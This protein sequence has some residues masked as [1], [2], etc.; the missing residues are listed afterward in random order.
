MKVDHEG[1]ERDMR[2]GSARGEAVASQHDW[3]SGLPRWTARVLAA[4]SVVTLLSSLLPF[5][6]HL[7]DTPRTYVDQYYF[8]V[9]DTSFAWAF[10]VMVLAGA[11]AGRKRLAWWLL[12]LYLL[13]YAVSNV[14]AAAQ[15]PSAH[16]IVAALVGAA[17]L[18]VLV[19]GYREFPARVRP[20]NV[21]KAV[22]VLV[23]GLVAATLLGWAL[24]ELFPGTLPRDERLAWAAND[25]LAFGNVDA[26]QFSGSTHAFINTVLGA[27]SAL[28][29]MA[30]AVVLLRSQRATNALTG[31]EEAAL[32]GLIGTHGESDSLA[33]FATRRDKAAVFAP[34]GRAAVTYRVEV[35]VCL[36][37]G[38]PIGDPAAWPQAIDAWLGLCATYGWTPAAMGASEV[39][40]TAY[41]KA[42]L[43][44]LELG[45]EAILLP[46]SFTIQGAEMK[47]VRQ[48]VT[49][50]ARAGV[51]AR[52][53]RHSAI[54]TAE[55][56]AAVAHADQWRDT[57]TERGFSMALG[58]LGDPA[59][60]DCLL[61][62]AVAADG[63]VVAMLSLAP[64]GRAGVSLDLMRRD[65]QAP[66]G[67][68]EFMVSE[69]MGQA[70]DLGINRVSLNFAVFR[71]VFEEGGKLGAGPVLRLWRSVL[72][73]FSRWWQLESLYRSNMKFQ[74]V[75]EPRY[76]CFA[77]PHL[78]PRIGVASGIAEGFI[79][80][81]RFRGGQQNTGVAAGPTALPVAA[82][83][84]AEVAP[85]RREE[86]VAVRVRK[87]ERLRA[88]GGEP[89]PTGEHPTHSIADAVAATE[90]ATVAGRVLRVRDHG[91][92]LFADVQD[93]TG[94]VQVLLER[95]TGPDLAAFR[96]HVDLGDLLQVTGVMGISGTG[97][98][99]LIVREWRMD[100]KCL[101]P[102]PDKRRGLVDPEA[103]VRAR[104]LDLAI[105]PEA[106][107]TVQARSA[108]IRSLRDSLNARGY[109]EVETPVLQ[110]VHGGANARPFE[111]HIN[112]YR[113]DLFLRIAPELYLK[114][115]CVGGMEKVFE[116]GRVFRNEGADYS[117]NPEFTILEA[118]EAH[119]D[120]HR[121]REVCQGLI[122][123][124]ATAA[125][126]EC[127]A[128]R[129]GADGGVEKVDLSGTWAVKTV[130]Q[131]ISE[132]LGEQITP[133]TEEPEL[134]RLCQRAGVNIRPGWGAGEIVLEMYEHMVEKQTL[135]PTFYMDFPTSVS[136]LT[137]PH[138][139]IPGVAERWD[140]VAYGF[141]LGTAYSE[142]T[143]PIDQRARLTAQS[144]R[145]A[146]G[147]AEAMALDEDFLTAI[148]YAM[149]P[150][151][152][153]GMG[154]DRLV[155]FLT[156]LSIRETLAFPL[157]APRTGKVV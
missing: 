75:W 52:I 127:V 111:T 38:D 157:T 122:Q 109:L 93:W 11:I 47:Q 130:Y 113:L 90:V 37:S 25:V 33:Y 4:L 51:T 117:H 98:P 68:V 85:P 124:A 95:G 105:N 155:M 148:E 84:A 54:P 69:L 143:D 63:A 107:R 121:M 116:L 152:G 66:N 114:R 147:D 67:V 59:D 82:P 132:K 81:P 5:F 126:G 91:G 96:R 135:A 112:A 12:V 8:D 110:Q 128:L 65:P 55:M 39:G 40:A 133:Q 102:M 71:A 72:L 76:L 61:V 108:I 29:L 64:W 27:L 16:P 73:F 22:A 24:V 10:V 9:P 45:D 62:E 28:A 83:T 43:G 149:P 74:P 119:S 118:Y 50:V 80:R 18:A 123:G 36:A 23:G 134:R 120:Y 115:L 137:R 156:G 6:R 21:W 151:G 136:P 46:R 153:L 89:Y 142:L 154:V 77:D 3:R 31:A 106:R 7:I 34:T 141:E 101:R 30:A 78:L 86:Q 144:L 131:A 56:A 42:G 88:E 125:H 104:Y 97:T 140:L 60:G 145:A 100:A 79:T 44:A 13:L 99:S 17:I 35:G 41:A 103:R 150:T 94:T 138:R 1:V 53:R 70:E 15:D 26:S 48:A 14:V 20:G 49:R 139:S 92:V 19:A 58:R 57:E 87:V 32:R 146:G 129:R 2:A